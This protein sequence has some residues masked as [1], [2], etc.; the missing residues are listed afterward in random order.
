MRALVVSVLATISGLSSNV[1]AGPLYLVG[2]EPLA[3]SLC[4][5][6]QTQLLIDKRRSPPP[7]Q[8]KCGSRLIYDLTLTLEEGSSYPP[9]YSL[10]LLT[11]DAEISGLSYRVT[12][13]LDATSTPDAVLVGHVS[14]DTG[15]TDFVFTVDAGSAYAFLLRGTNGWVSGNCSVLGS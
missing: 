15:Y 7:N 2:C 6:E 14:P 12:P 5:Q 9:R 13:L 10:M 11:T 1:S 8:Q 4:G 3:A